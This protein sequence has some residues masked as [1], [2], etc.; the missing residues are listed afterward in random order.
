MARLYYQSP[1]AVCGDFMPFGEEGTFYLFYLRDPRVGGRSMGKP[2]GWDLLKTK[3][4]VHYEDLGNAIPHGTDEEQDQ[5]VFS[6]SV[7]KA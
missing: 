3:D 6:G 4:F 7:I 2:F 1:D 5:Y